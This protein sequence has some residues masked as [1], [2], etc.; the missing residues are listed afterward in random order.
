MS[1][2]PRDEFDRT[3]EFT[4]RKGVHREQPAVK[5]GGSGLG[6]LMGVGILALVVGLLSFL[7]LPRLLGADATAVAAPQTTAAAS[8][9]A[10][11]SSSDPAESSAESEPSESADSESSDS[12]A[13]EVSESPSVSA[14]PS[15]TAAEEAEAGPVDYAAAVGVYNGSSISGLAGSGLTKLQ[16]GGFTS[17]TAGNWTKKVDASVV[18]YKSDASRATALETARLLGI[19]TVYQTANI[20]AEISVVLGRSYG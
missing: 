1:K 11:A 3:P 14:T 15:E 13:P 16:G 20:P 4:D 19:A 8:S 5:G 10:L 12:S 2:Y 18:Y 9:P 7:V 6:L 17:V